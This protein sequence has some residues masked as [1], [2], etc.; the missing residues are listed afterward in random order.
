M[1]TWTDDRE[2]AMRELL[3]DPNTAYS[4]NEVAHIL[5]DRFKI[6]ISRNAVIGRCK[7]QGIPLNDCAPP[8]RPS[9]PAPRPREK[10]QKAVTPAQ[11][12]YIAQR[13]AASGPKL[14]TAVPQLLRCDDVRGPRHVSL[15]ELTD[16][17]CRWPISTVGAPDFCFCGNP[18]IEGMPY[19][20][21]HCRLAY[22]V[23][24]R[25]A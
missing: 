20:A 15:L 25:A 9:N 24:R 11:R 18:P 16:N 5:S 17:T 4:A 2:N 8:G 12:P 7:R 10:P 14:H 3:A 22:R 23:D 19:C 6:E 13:K 21:G 1:K